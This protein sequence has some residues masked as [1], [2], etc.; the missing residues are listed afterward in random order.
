ML[1]LRTGKRKYQRG[2]PFHLSWSQCRLR[3][4]RHPCSC[5]V[6]EARPDAVRSNDEARSTDGASLG[7]GALW[8]SERPDGRRTATASS[9]ANLRAAACTPHKSPLLPAPVVFARRAGI[10]LLFYL[11][12][13]QFTDMH[14]FT[15]TW[16]DFGSLASCQLLPV[17]AHSVAVAKGTSN[18]SRC[19]GG[20]LT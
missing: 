19:Y 5:E 3:H 15:I 8:I 6:G 10:V 7:D 18:T 14:D 12:F 13:K 2:A 9:A 20:P 1:A 11:V 4:F 16:R 17:K